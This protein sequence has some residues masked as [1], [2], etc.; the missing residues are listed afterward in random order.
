MNLIAQFLCFG[1]A[2]AA[3]RFLAAYGGL[4]SFGHAIYLGIGAYSVIWTL[5]ATAGVSAYWLA[6]VPLVALM[7]GALSGAVV[8]LLTAR[9]RGAA[10][11]MITF[12]LGELV[13]LSAQALPERFG[14]ESGLGA[15][16]GLGGLA[17]GISPFVDLAGLVA[18][19]FAWVLIAQSSLLL[20]GRHGVGRSMRLVRDHAERAQALG[21]NP[22]LVR[23]WANV[24][25]G[26]VA[27]LAGGLLAM[28]QEL[29]APEA[30]E[31]DRSIAL[32]LAAV[33]GGMRSAWGA[34]LGSAVYVALAQWMAIYFPSWSWWLGALFVLVMW[35]R[36]DGLWSRGA[37]A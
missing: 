24:I 3:W 30:F 4:F 32:M 6:L 26:A 27:A 15:D 14:G 18:L 1:L 22:V 2:C 17:A 28:L 33:I 29:S 23:W 25:S 16:R 19:I 7:A 36:P 8:G 5:R 31:A 11:A 35:W 21:L 37:N 20:M 13:H 34:W 10:F 12:G 9:T